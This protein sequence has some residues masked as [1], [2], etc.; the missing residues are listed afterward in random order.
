MALTA[1][2]QRAQKRPKRDTAAVEV[3]GETLTFREPATGDFFLPKEL[4]DQITVDYAEFP[5]T[6][7]DN[8]VRLAR[9][10]IP[11]KGEGD[12]DPI[13]LFAGIARN[14]Y[15]LYLKINAEFAKA[16]PNLLNWDEEKEKLGNGLAGSK[17]KSPATVSSGSA[18]S[19]E[20]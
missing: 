1:L 5:Q 10:Y 3:A 14:D 2:S 6:L 9:C 8:V 4:K 20:R 11:S 18:K 16:F 19:P 13:A 12:I 7:V 17:S 15:E